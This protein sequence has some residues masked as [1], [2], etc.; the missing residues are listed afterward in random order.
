MKQF[1]KTE[2]VK[3]SVTENPLKIGAKFRD[4]KMRMRIALAETSGKWLK[5]RMEQLVSGLTWSST[6]RSSY[7]HI[8]CINR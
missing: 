6:I 5:L 8:V 7:F 1:S 3:M 4:D 2:M